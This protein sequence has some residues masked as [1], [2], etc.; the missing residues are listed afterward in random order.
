MEMG[1]QV[2]NTGGSQMITDHDIAVEKDWMWQY[3]PEYRKSIHSPEKMKLSEMQMVF[4]LGMS[5]LLRFIYK[6]YHTVTCGDFWAV[7]CKEC[8]KKNH[9]DDSLHEIRL[10][11]DLNLFKDGV[12]LQ[13]TE[14]HKQF[15]EAWEKLH[16]NFKWGG[17]FNDGNHYSFGYRGRA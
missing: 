14:D 5:V 10:A 1:A 9:M 15:G 2:K 17:R 12:F 13:E 8:G 7:P 16:P 4:M 3:C 11:G 6:E